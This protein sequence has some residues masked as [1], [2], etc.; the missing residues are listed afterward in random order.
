MSSCKDASMQVNRKCC[1]GAVRTFCI[2]P[3]AAAHVLT[4]RSVDGPLP[5]S[6]FP[7]IGIVRASAVKIAYIK[8]HG[9]V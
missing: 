2:F 1:K 9:S 6:R 8:Q 4:R 7:A 5:R 3:E